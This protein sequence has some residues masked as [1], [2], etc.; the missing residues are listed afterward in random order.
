MMTPN[1][2]GPYPARSSPDPTTTYVQSLSTSISTPT[3]PPPPPPSPNNHSPHL[4]QQRRSARDNQR[5]ERRHHLRRPIG[6]RVI[7]PSSGGDGLRDHIRVVQVRLGDWALRGRQLAGFERLA[8]R[9]DDGADGDESVGAGDCGLAVGAGDE[10]HGLW[11]GGRYYC[12]D[13]AA[14][15]ARDEA[16]GDG[17][18]AG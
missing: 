8:V 12:G 7:V 15:G 13:A 2:S 18:G 10:L 3:P 5:R 1:T 14:V 16:H 6:A 4:N 9:A 11:A 17:S